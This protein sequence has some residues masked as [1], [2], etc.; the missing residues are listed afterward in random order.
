MEKKAKGHKNVIPVDHIEDRIFIIRGKR[1]L[2]D[3][4][5]ADLYGVTTKRLNEQVKRNRERFPDDF[6]FRL[7]NQEVINLR[8]QY[9]TSNTGS[10]MHGGRRNAPLVFTE[11]GAIM[12]ASVLNTPRA[13]EV[14]LYVVRAFVK[15]RELSVSHKELSRKIDEVERKV[16]R[17][18]QAIS[19]F[20]NTI[21]QLMEPPPG[22]K[23]RSIGFA[24]WKED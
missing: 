11:Y 24:P 23:K 9:A 3:S 2:I 16:K 1:V 8:S 6:S 14:S 10:R 5:L 15:L 21:R 4:D 18:D 12:A 20:I 22:K 13:V 7:R 19:E 17:H